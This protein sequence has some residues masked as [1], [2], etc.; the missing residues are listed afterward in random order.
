MR[1]FSS[2]RTRRVEFVYWVTCKALHCRTRLCASTP[3]NLSLCHRF[4]VCCACS[5]IK[6]QDAELQQPF[7]T[8]LWWRW[9][10]LWSDWDRHSRAP[11][12]HTAPCPEQIT[13][14]HPKYILWGFYSFSQSILCFSK[15]QKSVSCQ[16]VKE[17]KSPPS[18]HILCNK[19]GSS[20]M[21][22]NIL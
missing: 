17:N 14:S 5:S 4:S 21:A 20:P 6:R 9:A 1:R 3:F 12:W 8:V 22:T 13:A 15:S 11:A 18:W 10:S 2:D 16:Q 19:C 7:F